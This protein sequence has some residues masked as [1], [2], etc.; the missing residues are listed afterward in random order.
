[1]RKMSK[2]YS[3]LLVGL[4]AFALFAGTADAGQKVYK[5]RLGFFESLFGGIQTRTPSRPIFGSSD[6]AKLTW[7]EQN[8]I[9]K[10]NRRAS[11]SIRIFYGEPVPS[12]KQR[13]KEVQADQ[14]EPDPL[15]GL[16][17]GTVNY[18]PPLVVPVYDSAFLKIEAKTPEAESIRIELI[19]KATNIRT[20]DTE[21]KAILAFYGANSFKPL[22]TEGGHITERAKSVLK[23]MSDAA[24]DGLIAK[25]Y[26]PIGLSSFDNVDEALAGSQLKI[27]RFD[28]AMTVAAVKYARH[29]SGGQFDPNRLSLYNDIKP[30][31]VAADAVMKVIGYSPFPESYFASLVPTHP[32]YAIFKKALAE[33]VDGGKK[34]NVIA[35]GPDVKVGAADERIPAIRTRLQG[36]GIAVAELDSKADPKTLDKKLSKSLRNLQAKNKL[37]LTGIL[38]VATLDALNADHS[39]DERQRIVFNMERLRWLPKNLGS[40]FVFVNQPAYEVNVFDHNKVAWHSKV[41]VGKPMNQTYSFYDQIETVVFNPS[42]GVPASIIVNEYGPKSRKDPG[43]LDRNGF[44]LVDSNGDVISSR[45]I[46]WWGMGQAPTFG[47]QQPP[48]SGNALGELKFLFPN[49]HDIYMHDTPTK[50]LFTES[51]RAFSHGCVRVQ[52]PREFAAVLLNMSEEEVTQNLGQ[53]TKKSKKTDPAEAFVDSHSINLA[54]KVPVYLTYFT[55]WADDSGKIQF[56]ND[57]YG[58]DTAMAKAIAYNP[59]AKKPIDSGDIA[60][61]GGIN[62][63]LSQN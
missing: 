22:W 16:G 52:N 56:Y 30:Q 3:N 13:Q 39:A 61:A 55:A 60:T 25:N 26:M 9:D 23:L 2:F 42:W 19:N 59:L 14:S 50:N 4:A 12:K 46:D 63:G 21:R 34:L 44:K 5:K 31:T 45:D 36:L 54:E 53:R 51:S 17:L 48:G 1:M 58:R 49:G 20:V 24:V 7:W 41:I 27:A 8:Q 6:S 62:G 47:V 37:K 38:D 35:D 57:I 28:I 32:Q 33:T 29:L 11:E 15:P 10:Q 43:Y 18:F 40:R